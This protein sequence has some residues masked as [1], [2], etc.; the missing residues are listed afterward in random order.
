MAGC[1]SN[2]LVQRS[3]NVGTADVSGVELQYQQDFGNGFGVLANYTYTDS[4]VN[5]NAGQSRDM[6]GVSPNSFN[7]SGYYEN[8]II[9]AR[10]AYNF[11]DEWWPSG[12]PSGVSNQDYQQWDASLIWHL[13]ENIDL[14]LEAVNIFNETIVSEVKDY[15]VGY[16]ADEFGARY[17]VGAS[18]HF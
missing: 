3:R 15:D 5:D 1:G 11:R 17:Y 18:V 8:E 6:Q 4:K 13:N 2:C 10:I 14:S 16:I 9:S 7:A 12:E